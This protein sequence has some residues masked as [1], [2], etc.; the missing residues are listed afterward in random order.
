MRSVQ[1]WINE[2]SDRGVKLWVQGDR[3]RYSGS[4]DVLTPQLL[5]ELSKNKAEI[6]AILS[7]D[8]SADDRKKSLT[9][10]PVSRDQNLPLSFSQQRL[11]FLNELEGGESSAY[12]WPAPAIGFTGELDQQILIKAISEIVR[13]HE[14]LRTNFININGEIVQKI[15]PPRLLNVPIID[16]QPYPEAEQAIAVKEFAAAERAKPFDLQNG[17]I[18]RCQLLQLSKTSHVLVLAVH[19]IA[20]DGWFMGIFL[21]ELVSIYEAF[22]Q[23]N[24]SPLPE[25]PIQYADF[26]AWQRN[27]LQGEVLERHLN[28]WQQQLADIP[29][30]LELPTDYQR[31]PIQTFQ[32]NRVPFQLSLSLTQHLKK[33]SQQNGSTLFMTLL[34]AFAVL[35]SRYCEQPDIVIGSPI[36][37][38]D[39]TEVENLLGFFVN[40]LV[41]RIQIPQNSSFQDLLAQVKR[42]ALDAY[43]HQNLPFEKLVE[44]LQPER[45]LSY[46]PLFQVM[47]ILQNS[48]SGQLPMP[49][50]KLS[51]IEVESS[52]TQLDL[53]LEI[54]DSV[55]GLAGRFEYNTD[56]FERSTIDRMAKHF[57]NLLEAIATNPQQKVSQ[58]PL[59][60]KS[61]QQQI[62][63]DW[64]DTAVNYPQDICLHKL[65]EAQV[66]RTPDAI[67]VIYEDQ[68]LSYQELNQKANQLAHHLLAIGIQPEQLV[69]ICV[70][71]SLDM[72]VGLLG[73]LKA[74]AAY[75]PI[76]PSY[77]RDR[78]EYMLSDSQAKILIT[79][80]SLI[81]QIPEYS[82]LTI[83]L[84][85]E[86]QKLAQAS[87]L[88]P[89]VAIDSNQ[90]AYV[91]YTSGSTGKP[92]G[93]QVLH[94]GVTNFLLSMQNTPI[95][96]PDDV[97]VA[98]TT[99]C[100]DI[101]VLELYLPLLVGAK[102][103][104]A[105]RDAAR[106]AMLLHQLIVSEQATC[107]QA[108]PSTWRMLSE[109]GWQ[110]DKNF[111]V[112]CGG[113]NLPLSLAQEL[114]SK[115][116]TVWNLYGPTEATV[117]ATISRINLEDNRVTI[118]KPLA[119]TQLYVLDEQL[120]PVPIGVAGEMHIGGVQVA[121][122]YLNRPDLTAERFIPDPFSS[123]TEARLYKT[124]DR[125]R[126]LADG[127]IE[128]LGRIDFQV[129]LRGFRIELG[130]IEAVLSQHPAV[131]QAVAIVDRQQSGS[132]RLVA[133]IIGNSGVEVSVP[134][135]RNFLKENLP[136]YMV[137][138]TYEILDSFPLTQNGKI[139]RRALPKTTQSQTL[140]DSTKTNYPQDELELRIAQ[141]WQKLLGTKSF[142]T[143]DN[144]FEVGG[145]SLLAIRLSAQLEE[146]VGYP[147][148]IMSI[149]QSPTIIG[150]ANL[151]RKGWTPTWNH[152]V[153]LKSNGTN[154]PFFCIH[155]GFGEVFVY[156]HLAKHL[157]ANQPFYG[158]QA[159][160]LDGRLPPL[161]RIEQMA[162]S[163]LKEIK[164]LQPEGPYYIGGFCAGGVVAYEIAQQLHAQGQEVA[165]LALMDTGFETGFEKDAL[166]S[167]KE[168]WKMRWQNFLKVPFLEKFQRIA[169]KPKKYLE[170]LDG[171]FKLCQCQFY[172]QTKRS[173]PPDLRK[174][175]L[176][177]N[178]MMAHL[179]AI[180]HYRPQPIPY[181][182]TL[183]NTTVFDKTRLSDYKIL[184]SELA[185]KEI[186]YHI[187]EGVHNL[188][189]EEPEVQKIA[190]QL[191]TCLTKSLS[192]TVKDKQE[193]K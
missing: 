30:L 79:Q 135:L 123:Q 84:D 193:S 155:E 150:L 116:A 184:W 169:Q 50:L 179:E 112:L 88:N 11:W 40:N 140:Q 147:V 76:D 144:F 12:N 110:G 128:Y 115:N 122:G 42:T 109:I 163:Y 96:S 172:L 187:I 165:L 94:Q 180:A 106:D 55:N 114:T 20:A 161:N 91:I 4:E 139:D 66:E 185:L 133:Y 23:S 118:G 33:L 102:L 61:E 156:R 117:W 182:V 131:N 177:H 31:P 143:D 97:L 113:E 22:L 28:Y 27:W 99:I 2:L 127:A 19:H 146:V 35:L 191:Q 70:E 80:Q 176:Y 153:P 183:I 81:N 60:S 41:L 134:E 111:K 36:A 170:Q 100:F 48:P 9:I 92:K 15:Q 137:P 65:V 107:M 129:K 171:K 10:Q 138:V 120:Q 148:P 181:P 44:A 16:L 188:V 162:T 74:G 1:Q 45:N 21:R 75:V 98:V 89:Q 173:L 68:Q 189:F 141:V 6:I 101:A 159:Q 164:I 167:A 58:I 160:G 3:L 105:S 124:G 51:S 166:P 157:A 14:V 32:G 17:E 59:L 175:Y 34:T 67:A 72:L 57:Q 104:I 54:L 38:R 49:N 95:L 108:T 73:I 82:G 25:L 43:D 125:V 56:L 126:Y 86:Q 64:N 13:R 77:P 47:F 90:L 18:F 145:H 192:D 174:F 5:A 103:A 93:V 83:S 71:R 53:T 178:N 130:E 132:D 8:L 7:Q 190:L 149:F 121:R 152:L 136:E 142:S 26:A 87:A 24:P 62:L 154:P 29:P 158:L 37:N 69:G 78:I 52:T 168:F 151:L 186:E 63:I 119:N 46:H 39:R 85:A